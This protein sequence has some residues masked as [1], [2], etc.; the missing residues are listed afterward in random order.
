MET[1]NF[2]VDLIT[3][4]AGIDVKKSDVVLLR[5]LDYAQLINVILIAN[6]NT[7]IV[8]KTFLPYIMSKK[9][10]LTDDSVDFFISMLY[11][12]IKLFKHIYLYKPMTSGVTTGEFYIIGINYNNN[13][14]NEL[15][16]EFV[17]KLENFNLNTKIIDIDLISNYVK[18]Q[19]HEYLNNI[20]KLNNIYI[21]LEI[22]FLNIVKKEII[23]D[24]FI[25]SLTKIK[26]QKINYWLYQFNF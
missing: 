5:K 24:E 25:K 11:I 19:I 12:Y 9:E 3:S 16:K 20:I 8:I 14:T 17:T 4:D 21:Q 15:K 10:T 2:N 22:D 23:T 18:Y 1:E 26:N 7:N 6:E 13:I